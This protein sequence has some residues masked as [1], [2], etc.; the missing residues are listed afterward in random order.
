MTVAAGDTQERPLE[1]HFACGNGLFIAIECIGHSYSTKTTTRD[2]SLS[3]PTLK[4]NWQEG[5]L[6]P[7]T[8]TYRHAR[9]ANADIQDE[10]FDWGVTVGFHDEPDGSQAP[11]YARISRL[12]F[13]TTIA[14]T[15][16]AA[17]FFKVRAEAVRELESCWALTSSW[18]SIFTRQNSVTVGKAGSGMRVGSIVNWS[19]DNNYRVNVS[20]DTSSPVLSAAGVD[21]LDHQT[22]TACLALAARQTMPPLEWT[23]IRD[24]RSLVT[25]K[26]YRRAA[27]DACTASELALT[28][29]IDNKFDA[30]GIPA[31]ARKAQFDT[32]HG[33]S[34]LT[35]LHRKVG[36]AGVLPTRLVQDVGA[37]RNKAAHRGYDPTPTETALAIQTATTV[38]ELVSPLSGYR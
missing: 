8:W 31:A 2:V 11:D 35:Q 30:D 12:R 36:A 28:A 26:E 25:A 22:L 13:E 37:L 20:T 3:L 5:R 33:I 34:K 7:P 4:Q 10:K 29:L 24:A 23:F 16:L 32:H 6:D 15:R 18:I 38:V 17:D 14:T 1:G 9:E 27:I 21:I 19:G